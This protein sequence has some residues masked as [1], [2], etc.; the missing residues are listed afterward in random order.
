MVLLRRCDTPKHSSLGDVWRTMDVP[1]VLGS[2][3]ATSMPPPI[4]YGN[5]RAAAAAR[6]R[7][8]TPTGLPR[9]NRSESW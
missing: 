9:Y 7:W 1:Q 2:A 5:W 8:F 3:N 6:L 4:F